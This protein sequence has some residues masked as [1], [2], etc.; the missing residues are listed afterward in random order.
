MFRSAPA[1][2]RTQV[3]VAVRAPPFGSP[4]CIRMASCRGI[5]R[6]TLGSLA[7]F[8]SAHLG[9]WPVRRRER[10]RGN[11]GHRRAAGRDRG[12]VHPSRGCAKFPNAPLPETRGSSRA[13]RPTPSRQPVDES[14]APIKA[15]VTMPV[16]MPR[17]R[18]DEIGRLGQDVRSRGRQVP[19]RRAGA[20]RAVGRERA[21]LLIRFRIRLPAVRGTLP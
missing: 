16:T 12:A 9:W 18:S 21:E 5:S 19:G 20:L 11:S 15:A 3:A 13:F 10:G 4:R 14:P 17:R 7:S 6:S 2:N 8:T 1:P